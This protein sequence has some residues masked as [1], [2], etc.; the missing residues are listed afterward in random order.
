MNNKNIY[1]KIV[2]G[3]YIYKGKNYKYLKRKKYNGKKYKIN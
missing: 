3:E 1:L 2:K